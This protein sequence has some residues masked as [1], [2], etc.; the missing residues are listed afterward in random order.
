MDISNHSTLSD[1]DGYVG[2]MAQVVIQGVKVDPITVMESSDAIGLKLDGCYLV[3]FCSVDNICEH[4]S[5]CL[6]DWNGVQCQCLSDNYEGKACHFCKC[7]VWC[8]VGVVCGMP[9]L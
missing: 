4:N 5:K 1:T 8:G 9:L 3:D 6:S 2:C 7:W